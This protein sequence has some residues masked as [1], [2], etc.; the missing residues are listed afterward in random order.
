[1][2]SFTVSWS[3][4]AGVYQNDIYLKPKNSGSYQMIASVGGTVTSY[5]IN[6]LQ[7][8][9]IYLVKIKSYC[10]SGTP[11]ETTAVE[12]IK[13]TCPVVTLTPACN[14]IINYSF[15]HLGAD[16]DEYSVILYTSADAVVTTQTKAVAATVTGSFTSLS[17]TTAYKVRVVPKA[18]TYS[19]TDCAQVTTTTLGLSPAVITHP[20]SISRCDDGP[21]SITTLTASFSGSSLTYS[22]Y[23]N[24]V[25]IS[26]GGN[27]SGATTASLTIQNA[28]SILGSFTCKASNV[29]GEVTTNAAVITLLADTAISVAPSIIPTCVTDPINLSVTASGES[30]TYQ[31]QKSTDGGSTYANISSATNSTYTIAGGTA[32]EGNKYRVVV[33]STCGPEI[34]S[35][36]ATV[37]TVVSPVI[38]TQP[39]NQQACSGSNGTFTVAY[40][41][42]NPTATIWQE[43]L[44]GIWYDINGATST[45]YS[46]STVGTYRFKVSNVCGTVYSNAVT[47]A[48]NIPDLSWNTLSTSVT[49]CSGESVT[50]TATTIGTPISQ[51]W[52]FSLNGGTT[53]SDIPGTTTTHTINNLIVGVSGTLFRNVAVGTC[54]TLTSA[55]I[56]LTVVS[57]TTITSQPT[58]QTVCA[59]SNMTVS[60]TA[61]G[62]TL[63]YQWQVSTNGGTSWANISGATSS[64]YQA[65]SVTAGISGYKYR[66]IVTGC[67][68]VT[69]D[70]ATLTVQ[71]LL[72]WD[73]T[74]SSVTTCPGG[75]TTLQATTYNGVLISQSWEVSTD[76]G[77]TWT[78]IPGQTGSTY[79]LTSIQYSQNGYR[80]RSIAVGTCNT[81]TLSPILL[82]VH[83]PVSINTQPQSQSICEGSNATFSVAATGYALTYQ[84]QQSSNSG[85]TWSNISGATSSTLTLTAPSISTSGYQYR[86]VVS[87]CT[88]VNSS[89]A[90]LTINPGAAITAQPTAQVVCQNANATF[91]VTATGSGITYQWQLYDGSSWQSISEGI[92]NTLVLTSVS[93]AMSGNSYRVLVSGTCGIVTSNAALLTVNTASPTW[94]NRDINIYYSCVGCDKYYIQL[95]TNPCSPT[96]NTTQTGSLAAS[97][98]TTCGGCCGLST[99]P[100]WTNE[101][102]AY[103]ESCVSKQLQRDTNTCSATYNQ[104]QV[105]NSGSA[106]IA[107]CG[108]ST[109]PTWTN[110]GAPYCET[111]IS[112][113]LQR[114]TNTCSATYNQ[115]QIVAGGTSC[116]TPAT[117]VNRDINTY[118]V[119]VGV[120]KHYEQIDTNP[121]SATYNQTQTGSLY[122][123]NSVDCGY[124][125]PTCDPPTIT[126]STIEEGVIPPAVT[127]LDGL[128]IETIYIGVSSDLTLL[129][130]GYTHPCQNQVGAHTC[131]RAFFEVFGNGVYIGDSKLNNSGGTGGA[132]TQ[133]G[134]STCQDYLNTPAPLTGGTWT[135]NASSRY[136]SVTISSAQALAI[137]NAAGGSTIT[138][139]LVAAMTTYSATCDTVTVP[140]TNVTWTRITKANGDV[141]YNGCPNN[142]FTTI[143]VCV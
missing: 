34:T 98:S 54:N 58:N 20:Q 93:L 68:V 91:T 53:W 4:G 134:A 125:P 121:C 114:D 126:S 120:N 100:V 49:K 29:C 129:P 110:E 42:E 1:M 65:I 19:K 2:A 102:A 127:C 90:T 61:T 63:T 70:P 52:Q 64:S 124:T 36:A 30:L 107:C 122:Q 75:S 115:T 5:V 131:D 82:T 106:C 60:V 38:N 142:N 40:T 109:V 136:S 94:V 132:I 27:Y 76:G 118:Y 59:G 46:T 8:N 13:F 33:N 74:T 51:I 138:F 56:T 3:S 69:S 14:G 45:T 73:N 143:D 39:T 113:Q 47:L 119:C 72:A 117:W 37:D 97:N 95:D 11:V 71:N 7:D 21:N 77:S 57:A 137:A 83:Q 84:W 55:P 9:T 67:T 44:G 116:V 6:G 123:A 24:G 87:G 89:A 18:A 85:S 103:C 15:P 22:W 111:C 101:G 128:K 62:S 139:S 96:Y 86:V 92:S 112:K 80:Y 23:R 17:P 78:T 104:T 133:S 48:N 79:L 32:V 31:W 43:Q 99:S 66:V 10:D 16:V 88:N 140:H 135:G 105:I 50:F 41:A 130:A 81:L 28:G 35:A 108:Q 141:L 25:L 12:R 26:N